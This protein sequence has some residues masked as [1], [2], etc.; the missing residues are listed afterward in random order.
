MCL[1]TGK[2]FCLKGFR[3]HSDSPY[4]LTNSLII[5]LVSQ[6]KRL[7][8]QRSVSLT[9]EIDVAWVAFTPRTICSH[10]VLCL[11]MML[12]SHLHSVN[13]YK[14]LTAFES[15]MWTYDTPQQI[16][17]GLLYYAVQTGQYRVCLSFLPRRSVGV[18]RILS[19]SRL[20]TKG[21][22]LHILNNH[23]DQFLHAILA[24]TCQ[25]SITGNK[26]FIF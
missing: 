21:V 15:R 9:M 22:T 23:T 26:E 11:M 2:R 1:S 25:K 14:F 20:L 17:F 8:V 12:V 13:C 5:I 18:L 16:S 4:N 19:L 3:R 24:A 10:V 6:T 7:S